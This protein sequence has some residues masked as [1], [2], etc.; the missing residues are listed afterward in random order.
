MTNGFRVWAGR[1]RA[2]Q[3]ADLRSIELQFKQFAQQNWIGQKILTYTT[4]VELTNFQVASG[5]LSSW[6]ATWGQQ[7]SLI[8]AVLSLIKSRLTSLEERALNFTEF[9]EMV[10]L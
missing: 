10:K 1:F 2:L 6:P 8:K 5:K 7:R 4:K 9:L 3:F